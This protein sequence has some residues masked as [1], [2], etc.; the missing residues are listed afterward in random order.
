MIFALPFPN[1]D[2]VLIDIG[3]IGGFPIAIRWYGLLWL[4]G[5]VGAWWWVL[6]YFERSRVKVE[7]QHIDDFIDE[8]SKRYKDP[9]QY[10]KWITGQPQQLEQFKM[11]VLEKQLVE[12][13]ENVLKSKKK[14]IKFSELANR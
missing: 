9:E 2:P 11:I 4:A 14:V 7:K 3:M 10:K 1:I 6:K 12:K 8:E 5:C 13:L